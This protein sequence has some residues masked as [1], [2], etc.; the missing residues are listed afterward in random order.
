MG[1]VIIAS[2]KA[3]Q[4][5]YESDRV[6]NGYSTYHLVSAVKQDSGAV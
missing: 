4:K 5:F 1:R 3:R 2:S 6:Q